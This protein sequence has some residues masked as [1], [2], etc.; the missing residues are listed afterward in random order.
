MIFTEID[1]STQQVNELTALVQYL[2]SRA[3]S[4]NTSP[5]INTKTFLKMAGDLGLNISWSQLQSFAQKQPLKNMITSLGSDKLSFG[6]EGQNLTMPVDKARDIVKKM[7][8]RSMNRA[9]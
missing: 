3:S 8:K 7:A 5:T 1:S 9:K 4:L 6:G 2:I